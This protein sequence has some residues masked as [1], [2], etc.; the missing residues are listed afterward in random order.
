MPFFLDLIYC[1]ELIT[2]KNIGEL[3]ANPYWV[4][5]KSE[6]LYLCFQVYRNLLELQ[7]VLLKKDSSYTS[8][9]FL[10][11]KLNTSNWRRLWGLSFEGESLWS[12]YIEMSGASSSPDALSR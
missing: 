3:K 11:E 7:I 10:R 1:S 6:A 4:D 12:Y 5:Q 9:P 8:Q 2:N